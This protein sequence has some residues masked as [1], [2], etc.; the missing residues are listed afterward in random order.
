GGGFLALFAAIELCVA[1]FVLAAGAAGGWHALAVATAA[2]IVTGLAAR[3]WRARRAWTDARHGLTNDLVEQMIGPRTRPAQ[4]DPA[5]WHAGEDEAVEA[6]TQ[7]SR[8]MDR[9]AA[10]LLALPRAWLL[11]GLAALGPAFVAGAPPQALAV[12]IGGVL[13]AW[14]GLSKL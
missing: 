12:S 3:L 2:A 4:Q 6:S 1:A 5:L 10:L 9:A 7:R 13:L 11:I 8:R 14:Q